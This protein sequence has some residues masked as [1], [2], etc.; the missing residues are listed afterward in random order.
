MTIPDA[1][2]RKIFSA[3]QRGLPLPEAT[4]HCWSL[5]MG[6]VPL[7]TFPLN[8]Q[9]TWDF[10]NQLLHWLIQWVDQTCHQWGFTSLVDFNTRDDLFNVLQT[11]FQENKPTLQGVYLVYVVVGRSEFDFRLSELAH[12][13][14]YSTRTLERRYRDGIAH[15][16]GWLQTQATGNPVPRLDVTLQTASQRPATPSNGHVPK[17]VKTRDDHPN[18]FV[19]VQHLAQR[20][21]RLEAELETLREQLETP[22]PSLY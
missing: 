2:F 21:S 16:N 8:L 15:F 14:G 3:L 11:I 7:P 9:T 12:R 17:A 18:L 19:E 20:I 22:S 5:V 4:Q 13:M 1:T 6:Q 10:K